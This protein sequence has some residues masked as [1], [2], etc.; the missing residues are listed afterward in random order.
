MPKLRNKIS[1]SINT[2]RVMSD[3]FKDFTQKLDYEQIDEFTESMETAAMVLEYS[4]I[5]S[6]EDSLSAFLKK[7][8][9]KRCTCGDDGDIETLEDWNK[10]D[11][12]LAQLTKKVT[13]NLMALREQYGDLAIKIN[14]RTC[15]K[16][17]NED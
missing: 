8:T 4:V 17:S 9:A 2:T 12:W 6:M 7:M 11:D 16:R 15:N 5:L 13:L 3:I 14:E 10:W 1:E